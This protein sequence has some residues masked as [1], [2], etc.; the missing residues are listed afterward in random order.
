MADPGGSL[1]TLVQPATIT[2]GPGNTP[3]GNYP[4]AVDMGKTGR[5]S[6]RVSDLAVDYRQ[7]TIRVVFQANGSVN[8]RQNLVESNLLPFALFLAPRAETSD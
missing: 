3:L 4:K 1:A 7:F 8:Q 2:D 5:A 6:V